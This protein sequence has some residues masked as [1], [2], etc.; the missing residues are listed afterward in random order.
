MERNGATNNSVVWPVIIGVA[1]GSLIA[2]FLATWVTLHYVDKNLLNI[3]KSL[4]QV[5][6]GEQN[7]E[8]EEEENMENTKT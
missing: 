4:Q 2:G 1:V 5:Q 8:I 3:Q 7:F 6:C